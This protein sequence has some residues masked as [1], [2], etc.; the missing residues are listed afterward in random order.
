MTEY[1]KSAMVAAREFR[2]ENGLGI[3]PIADV[4]TLIEQTR[5]VDV[6][7]LDVEDSDEHGLTM[8]DPARGVT[9]VGVARSLHP[10]RWRSTLG[11]ELG[12]LVFDDHHAGESG[13][14]VFNATV[15]SR[16]QAF[17]RHLLL[18]VE[19]VGQFMADR[20]ALDLATFSDLVQRFQISPKIAAIQL[21]DSGYRDQGDLNLFAGTFTPS[22]AARFGWMDQY[23]ALQV[24]S[25]QR[26]SP[27]RLLARAV[28][29][30]A[31]GVVTIETLAGVRGIPAAD[32]ATELTE[33]GVRV[34]GAV[35]H[36]AD[37]DVRDAG[38]FIDLSWLDE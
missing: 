6:A 27:Q 15:E 20:R 9:I 12:H 32:L 30:Y 22:L 37:R 7:V 29:G 1:E 26:R 33:A 28:A 3:A 31:A 38:E 25:S 34:R 19:A 4:V 11:H 23:R 35:A 5:D 24:E 13:S 2:S 10:M 21:R 36:P 18:P 17:A 16:A 8:I 14:L